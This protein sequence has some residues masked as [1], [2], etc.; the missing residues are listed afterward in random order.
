MHHEPAGGGGFTPE[1]ALRAAT[2]VAAR[3]LRLEGKV[4]VL[5]SG[6][7]ADMVLLER[8]PLERIQNLLT[9]RKVYLRGREV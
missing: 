8:S 3:A 2:A 6:A 5:A 7:R 4:G 1:E 9:I